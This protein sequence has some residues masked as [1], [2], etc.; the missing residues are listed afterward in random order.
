MKL[1]LQLLLVYCSLHA[2]GPNLMQKK[3]FSIVLK[4]QTQRNLENLRRLM[5]K[6]LV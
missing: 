2:A 3:P 6:A 1:P 5:R 4:T